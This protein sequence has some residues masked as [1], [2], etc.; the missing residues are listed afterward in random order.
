MSNRKITV[1]VPI[2]SHL[3]KFVL[4]ALDAD[5]PVQVTEIDFLGRSIMKVLQETRS[6]KFANVLEGYTERIEIQL[7]SRMQERNYRLHR[8]IHINTE[9]DKAFRDA[10]ILFVRAQNQAGEP[11]NSACKNF[12]ELLNI[13]ES[14]F[15]Y[16]AAYKA[17]QRFNER[18]REKRKSARTLPSTPPD[19]DVHPSG[20]HSLPGKF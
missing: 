16:D 10:I 7:T 14:E 2:K 11:S 9:L 18:T 8:L 12:L 15:S 13:D 1:K 4:W 5:E 17:W 19:R 6:H 3:K 20:Q